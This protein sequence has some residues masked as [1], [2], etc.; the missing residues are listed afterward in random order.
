[1]PPSDLGDVV[2]AQ[3]RELYRRRGEEVT[4]APETDLAAIGF[5]SLDFAEL[6]LLVEDAVGG[7]LDLERGD[8][9][10]ID[11]VGD[12]IAFFDAVA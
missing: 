12:L 3:L 7:Q 2:L 6:V 9:T 8:V 11:T 1:M 10:R 5:R 4:A